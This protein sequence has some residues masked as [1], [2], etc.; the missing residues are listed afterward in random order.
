MMTRQSRKTR[1]DSRDSSIWKLA[2]CESDCSAGRQMDFLLSADP[3]KNW[4]LVWD[5]FLQICVLQIFAV[6]ISPVHFQSAQPTTNLHIRWLPCSSL[7]SS[8]DRDVNLYAAWHIYG[9]TVGGTIW[10]YDSH[11]NTINCD[12]ILS[13]MLWPMGHG[14]LGP[15]SP[16]NG[17]WSVYTDGKSTQFRDLLIWLCWFVKQILLRGGDFDS[18]V[19]VMFSEIPW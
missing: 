6:I 4:V 13:V 5:S 10:H 9:R 17:H 2:R 15:Q 16:R 11:H 3:A 1:P 14:M 7:L 19:R 8:Q 18:P 12:A